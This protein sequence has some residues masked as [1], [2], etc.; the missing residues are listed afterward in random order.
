MIAPSRLPPAY[1]DWNRRMGAPF[2]SRLERLARSLPRGRGLVERTL[3]RW[4]PSVRGPFAI[5]PNNTIRVFEYPWAYEAI[6]PEPGLRV[7]DIGGGLAGMQFVLAR[8]GASVVNVD[9]GDEAHGRGWPVDERS[10]ARLNRAFGTSVELRRTFLQDAGLED[11]SFDRVLSISTI[12]HIPMDELPGLMAHVGRLLR[13]GGL[14]VATVDLFLN[15]EPFTDRASN[16]YGVNVPVRDLVQWGGLELV[17]G[18]RAELYGYPEFDPRRILSRLED[19]MIGGYP[20][21]AQA[22]VAR[23]PEAP[24]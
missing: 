9:P 23:K 15:L 20:A 17:T 21:L 10:I 12:E 6:A 8:A 14:F 13:P 3:F 5:Q 2:G 1:K 24:A 16:E 11:D 18:D 22:F 4:A 19:Y 7:L